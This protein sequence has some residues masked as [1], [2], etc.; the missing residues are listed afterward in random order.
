MP[1]CWH[2]HGSMF[3]SDYGIGAV[4]SQKQEGAERV[5][6]YASRQ[7]TKT[8]RQQPTTE[9][10]ALAMIWSIKQFR[11]YL[12]GHKFALITDHQPL[13]W[14]KSLKDPPSQLARW[15]TT[16]QQYDFEV[17]YRAGKSYVNADTMSRVPQ[18]GD[19]EETREDDVQTDQTESQA[20]TESVF[21]TTITQPTFDLLKVQH[22]DPNIKQLINWKQAM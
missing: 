2:S 10:E 14:L 16:L 17:E 18:T 8:E 21:M 11:Q 20:W 6:A 3:H 19:D 9:K 7:L 22:S 5:I 13:K 15:V 12:F 1:L 4:L